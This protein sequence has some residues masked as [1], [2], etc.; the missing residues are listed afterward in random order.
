MAAG[1]TVARENLEEF[2]DRFEAIACT[3]PDELFIPRGRV[4][5]ELDLTLVSED[6]FKVLKQ[7]EPHGVGNPLPTF[8]VRRTKV[9]VQRFF[10]KDNRHL[11]LLL[12]GRV[13]GV[14]WRGEPYLPQGWRNGGLM[15]VVFQLGWDD[16]RS[17]LSLTVK[18]VGKLNTLWS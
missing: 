4:D 17:R 14:F 3:H 12:D 6:L 16:F 8:A 2:S 13:Q 18:D 1:L 9:V 15:D 7:L 10:G 5:M 11:Q